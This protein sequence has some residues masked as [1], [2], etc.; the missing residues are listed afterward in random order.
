MPFDE[1]FKNFIL[2]NYYH[3]EKRLASQGIH[4]PLFVFITQYA[5]LC[6]LSH[7]APSS[8]PRGVLGGLSF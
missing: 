7:S 6:D 5:F 1:I 4:S 2:V 8:W 3:F